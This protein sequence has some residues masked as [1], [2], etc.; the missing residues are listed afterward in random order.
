MEATHAPINSATALDADSAANAGVSVEWLAYICLALLAL[1]LR[2]AELDSLPLTDAEAGHAL[3]AWHSVEDDA[4]GSHAV[5]DSPLLHISQLVSFS[6]LGAN[7]FSAR[8]LPMLVGWLLTLS[9]LLFRDTL[10]RTRAFVWACLL[11]LLT[12]P[13][14]SSRLAADGTSFMMLFALLAVWMIRRYWYT[15][16]LSDARWAVA[17]VTL[18]TL[19]SAPAGIPLLAVM[20]IAGWLAVWRTAISAPQRLDLPGDDHFE[21]GDAAYA[22]VSAGGHS[23]CASRCRIAGLDPVYAVSGWTRPR[24]AR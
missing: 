1:A 4:P 8:L 17:L 2:V 21:A 20:L 23:L 9:P 6:L 3:H 10:G 14:A 22:R 18:M 15:R 24:S 19:L 11:S 16:Q 7:A 12:L 13:I 5:S